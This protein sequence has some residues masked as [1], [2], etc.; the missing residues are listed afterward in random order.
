MFFVDS[1]MSRRCADRDCV[2]S[3]S[4]ATLLDRVR[5][6]CSYM[7]R[8]TVPYNIV[9]GADL[10]RLD[11]DLASCNGAHGYDKELS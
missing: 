9:S 1:S 4:V 5:K 7:P 2:S 11:Y 6:L 10:L 3:G 8:Q